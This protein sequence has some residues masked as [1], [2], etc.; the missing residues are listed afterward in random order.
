MIQHHMMETASTP[1][2]L[3][4]SHSDLFAEHLECLPYVPTQNRTALEHNA[5]E[6]ILGPGDLRWIRHSNVRHRVS[7][8]LHLS[9]SERRD[10]KMPEKQTLERAKQDLREGKSPSTT[11]GE[12]V[13]EEIERIRSGNTMVD[14]FGQAG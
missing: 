8:L 11:A 12:F 7:A 4:N 13:H 2:G 10:E 14:G 6:R 9:V 3:P 1:S 5:T